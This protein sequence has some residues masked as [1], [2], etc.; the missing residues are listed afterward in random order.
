MRLVN[1]IQ[2]IKE[3]ITHVKEHGDEWHTNYYIADKVA[4]GWIK[5]RQ[6]RIYEDGQTVFLLRQRNTFFHLYYFAS[7]AESFFSSLQHIMNSFPFTISV[8]VI[9][10]NNSMRSVNASFGEADFSKHIRLYRMKLGRYTPVASSLLSDESYAEAVD[11]KDIY[12]MLHDNFDELCEQ[13]PDIDEI[14][15]AAIEH[16]IL[17]KKREKNIISI[18]WLERSG[19]IA[20]I[21]YW[22]TLKKYRSC[23]A[24]TELLHRGLTLHNNARQ[25]FVWVREDNQN[26]IRSYEKAGFL[27]DGLIDDVYCLVK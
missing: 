9:K 6:L 25:T 1:N 12:A 22:L 4:E 21:R 11:A 3:A 18:L 26:A 10:K 23:G 7:S 13:I 27:K 19:G 15:Q 17:V 8:D 2:K 5:R 16:Q 14:E 24:G 20:L